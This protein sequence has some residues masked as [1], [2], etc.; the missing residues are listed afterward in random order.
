VGEGARDED[1]AQEEAQVSVRG[2]RHA[3]IQRKVINH[4]RGGTFIMCA[5]S[6]CDRDGYELYKV[7][8]HEH[9]QS[10]ACDSSL[11]KHIS[12]VFCSE[13]HKQ[14]WVACTGEN[15]KELAARYGGRQA[16]MLPPGL[17]NRDFR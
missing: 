5:W 14:Y 11:A 3:L 17:R 13:R 1:Q 8:S 7:T 16:G 10:I 15:A 9:A 2:T 12:Y 6:D 4:D